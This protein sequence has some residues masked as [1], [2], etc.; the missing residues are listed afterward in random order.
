MGPPGFAPDP[1]PLQGV[2]HLLTPGSRVARNLAPLAMV[3]IGATGFAPATLRP[4]AESATKLR[5]APKDR[6]TSFTETV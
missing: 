4:P 3:R 6:L 2:M 5:H 1:S